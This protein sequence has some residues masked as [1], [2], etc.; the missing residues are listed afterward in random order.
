MQLVSVWLLLSVFFG[1]RAL[2]A[3]T[4][5]VP[6]MTPRIHR[7]ACSLGESMASKL[8]AN[9]IPPDA[10]QRTCEQLAPE[11]NDAERAD[12]MRCCTARLKR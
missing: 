7:T 3:E 5:P 2:A 6:S 4:P 12:F 8:D 1:G 9:R 10:A 11:M